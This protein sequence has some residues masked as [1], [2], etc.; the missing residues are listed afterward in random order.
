[1]EK[2][3]AKEVLLQIYNETLES[4]HLQKINRALY[5][6]LD[7]EENI[8][9]QELIDAGMRVAKKAGDR[10]KE[11]EEMV[12][13]KQKT[14]EIVDQMIQDEED[15]EKKERDEQPLKKS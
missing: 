8:I 14:L 5:A 7:P 11:V 10:L 12:E 2:K 4:L 3:T 15:R 13:T 6:E 9:P 1:M